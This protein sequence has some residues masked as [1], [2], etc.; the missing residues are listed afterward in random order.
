MTQKTD[1]VASK[2]RDA[3]L[4]LNKQDSHTEFQTRGSFAG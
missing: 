1:K 4:P 2:Q 3:Q